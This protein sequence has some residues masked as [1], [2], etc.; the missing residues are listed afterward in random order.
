MIIGACT[1]ELRLGGAQSLKDKRRVVKSAIEQVRGRFNVA[2]AEVDH[3]D[4][5]QRATLGIVTVS[6]ETAQVD[7]ILAAVMSYL[8]KI[9]ALE[10]LDYSTEIL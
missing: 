4:R 9:D 10:V 3:L 8:M 2:V 6:N 1:V 5:W 7:R